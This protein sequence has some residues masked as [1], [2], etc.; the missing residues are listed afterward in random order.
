[1]AMNPD[2]LSDNILTAFRNNMKSLSQDAE[3]Q[4][5]QEELAKAVA[6]GTINVLKTSQL[7]GPPAPVVTGNGV[8]LIVD[9]N[10]MVLTATNIIA[11]STGGGGIALLKVMQSLL[12]PIGPYLATNV[13]VQSISG[14]GGQ[15][16][17][18]IGAVAPA[19][20]AAIL[21]ELSQETQTNLTKSQFGLIMI[22][23]L[24]AGLGTGM[25]AA[26]PG[27]VPFG[28]TPPAA[29]PLVAILK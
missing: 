1:M 21:A 19:F 27:L 28:T 13:D 23:A 29:A 11:S 25:A 3:P 10:L 2:T 14:F 7:I 20:Q 22:N 26:I 9:A 12:G 15:A 16:G 4:E 8:G 24:A 18:P 6:T 5:F 17:P